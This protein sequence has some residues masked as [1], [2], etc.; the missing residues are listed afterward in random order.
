MLVLQVIPN[1][2]WQPI[3]DHSLLPGV[4][5]FIVYFI[6]SFNLILIFNY[7]FNFILHIKF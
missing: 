5:Y 1:D 7:N 6:L 4:L 2:A 3:Q